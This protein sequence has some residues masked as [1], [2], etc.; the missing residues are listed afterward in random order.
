[1]GKHALRNASLPAMT[2]L[3]LRV[4]HLLAGSVIIE[5]IFQFRGLGTYAL[6]AVSARDF[7]VVQSVVLVI[8]I[9]VVGVN[10]LVD[11]AYSLLNPKVRLS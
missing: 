2:I 3:G 5:Q 6:T 10:L 4:G 8:A 7:V 1:M 11:L 9:I